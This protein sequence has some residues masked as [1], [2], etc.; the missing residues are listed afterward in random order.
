MGDETLT[1]ASS[2]VVG[3]LTG[4]AAARSVSPAH[5][6]TDV[7]ARLLKAAWAHL[8]PLGCGAGNRLAH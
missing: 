5:I 3:C 2:K 6:H 1:S 8:L 7:L 4:M